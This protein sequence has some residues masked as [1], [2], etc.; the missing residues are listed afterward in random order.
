SVHTAPV[1]P[2]ALQMRTCGP[3]FPV[4]RKASTGFQ[5]LHIGHNA[6][7]CNF[8]APM[9]ENIIGDV[10]TSSSQIAQ[11]S[12]DKMQKVASYELYVRGQ[13]SK[14]HATFGPGATQGKRE[15]Q[16]NAHIADRFWRAPASA[17]RARFAR[18]HG[19]AYR[20]WHA[21]APF[22]RRIDSRAYAR[23]EPD[24]HRVG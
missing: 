18:R 4:S 20:A 14:E 11:P 19:T 13:W 24:Q 10:L 15:R 8:T 16:G 7:A 21:R 1:L 6:P 23:A 2:C 17:A 5:V 9:G 12:L 3:L 22:P